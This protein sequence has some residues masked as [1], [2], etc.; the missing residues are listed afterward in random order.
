MLFGGG[1]FDDYFGEILIFEAALIMEEE[2]KKE[3]LKQKEEFEKLPPS[4]R[5]PPGSPAAKVNIN[6]EVVQA[7]IKELSD[8][9]REFLVKKLLIRIEPYMTG[10]DLGRLRQNTRVIAEDLA[11][12]PGGAELLQLIGYIY[13][14]EAEQ[15]SKSFLGIPAFFS[16]VA[17]KTHLVKGSLFNTQK[18]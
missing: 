10:N 12:S 14:Q 1:K 8:K 3:E 9:R 13:I 11:D 15:H 16:E 5:P 18:F 6:E 2:Y 17:E 4:Q 7:K